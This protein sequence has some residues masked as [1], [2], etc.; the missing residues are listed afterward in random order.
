MHLARIANTY[1]QQ[2]NHKANANKTANQALL[3]DWINSHT[4]E[5]IRLANNARTLLKKLTGKYYLPIQDERNPKRGRSAVALFVQDRWASGD[6]K[7]LNTIDASKLIHNEYLELSKSEQ[8]V[9]A[10]PTG[11][12]TSRLTLDRHTWIG[13]RPTRSG[14]PANSSPR[15]IATPSS[16]G[17]GRLPRQK[18]PPEGR[19][20][21]GPLDSSPRDSD[22][23]CLRMGQRARMLS[24]GAGERGFTDG[25]PSAV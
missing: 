8:Q 25:V 3:K 7:G 18:R 13:R 23:C 24:L 9:S 21:L 4:A 22:R 19:S 5:Q 6:F 1:T 10:A 17:T 2:Y 20:D 12:Q 15:T 11:S 14:T 16:S